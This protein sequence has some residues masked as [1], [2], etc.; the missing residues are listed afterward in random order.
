VSTTSLVAPPASDVTVAYSVKVP[1]ADTLRGTY[2][3]TVMVEGATEAPPAVST[4]SAV[5][6]GMV[7]RYAVQVATHIQ[8]SGSRKIHFADQ[9][10]ERE[11][12]NTQSLHLTIEN[13]GERAYRPLLWMEVYDGQGALQ[14]SAK[15]Q[16]GLLY[17]GTSAKQKFS[18]SGL[19][20]GSYKAIVFADIGSDEVVAAQY[21]LSLSEPQAP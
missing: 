17:P 15:Q 21:K 9:H 19:K 4:G 8:S 1:L 18:L 2:W 16:R 3:S 6:L 10:V 5:G 7:V 14:A 20:P 11:Q 12:E 13:V